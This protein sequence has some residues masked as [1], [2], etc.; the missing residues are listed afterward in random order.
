MNN[1]WSFLRITIFMVVAV[2]V[3]EYLIDAGD[4]WAIIKYPIVWVVLLALLFFA[5]VFEVIAAAIK[6]V[7]FA[8]LSPEAKARY[9]AKHGEGDQAFSIW[10]QRFYKKSM[11]AKPVEDEQEIVLDHSYDGIRELDNNLPPWWVYMFYATMVFAV[12]Y[13]LRYHVFN[14][15]TQIEEY[16]IEVAEAKAAFEEYKKNNKDLIDANSVELLTDAKDLEAG[17]AIFTDNCIACHKAD[18]GGGIG[19]NL[20]DDYW[21]LGGGIKNVYH[22]ISEGGRPGKGM[23]PWKTDLKPVE[24]A[25]VASYVISLHG[26]NPADPKAPEGDLWTEADN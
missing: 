3:F 16:E 9:V 11:D 5:V 6:R 2:L 20:T 8:T 1:V 14:G 17:K 24:I 21:I 13:M 12:V 7:L 26:T 10:L 23:I 18:G 4:S 19:P 25:Q 22:T 15:T